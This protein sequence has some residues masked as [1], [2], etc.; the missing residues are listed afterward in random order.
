[1]QNPS[2]MNLSSSTKMKNSNCRSSEP[3]RRS[4]AKPL[5]RRGRRAKQGRREARADK[6]EV[7]MTSTTG[8]PSAGKV[9]ST[10]R[11]SDRPRSQLIETETPTMRMSIERLMAQSADTTWTRRIT[12]TTAVPIE[13]T[14]TTTKES[15]TTT[16][17]IMMNTTKEEKEATTP[18]N[19]AVIQKPMIAAT[20]RSPNTLREHPTELPANQ[21]TSMLST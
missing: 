5:R 6:K 17:T 10:E 7:A 1:M 15:M 11:R 4:A 16:T 13:G 21:M 9:R 12:S 3:L 20:I 8:T 2:L 14:H 19:I 18:S